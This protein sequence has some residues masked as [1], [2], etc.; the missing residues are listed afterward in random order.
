VIIAKNLSILWFAVNVRKRRGRVS[1]RPYEFQLFF[2]LFAGIL[3][4]GATY[5]ALGF[6]L[7]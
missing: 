4:S 7:A 1:N 2:A 5:I 3:L 6:N